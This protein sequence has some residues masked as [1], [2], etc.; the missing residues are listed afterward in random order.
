MG[1]NRGADRSEVLLFPETIDDYITADNPVRFINA[2]VAGLDLA[3]LGLARAIP[4]T[5]GRP[6]L[7][8]LNYARSL[9]G[10]WNRSGARPPRTTSS[11]WSRSTAAPSWTAGG[12]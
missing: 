3:A 2:F 1:H 10:W 12:L 7:R 11:S 9:T 8:A 5:T 4:A 6:A